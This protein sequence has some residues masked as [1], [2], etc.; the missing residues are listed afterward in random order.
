LH[1]Q[2][3]QVRTCTYNILMLYNYQ[4]VLE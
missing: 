4:Y 2:C 1:S 3:L